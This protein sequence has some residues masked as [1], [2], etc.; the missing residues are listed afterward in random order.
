MHVNRKM[1]GRKKTNKHF[2]PA[3]FK[4]KIPFQFMC[5]RKKTVVWSTAFEEHRYG[6]YFKKNNF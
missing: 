5:Q 4:K 1:T 3:H 2:L 6:K